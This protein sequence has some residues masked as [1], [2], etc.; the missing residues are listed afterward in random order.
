MIDL[1]QST[2]DLIRKE[3][4][5]IPEKYQK[6]FNSTHE[7]LGVLREEYLELE[8]EIFFGEKKALQDVKKRNEQNDYNQTPE[9]N[10]IDARIYHK[11]RIQKEAVQVA[12]MAIRI[13]QELTQENR[14]AAQIA[15]NHFEKLLASNQNNLEEQDNLVRMGYR[16]D[17]WK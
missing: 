9:F 4:N 5:S 14:T 10:Q 15:D 13:I 12:A 2:I 3:L 11:H 17:S 6:P 8:Q 7:G 1:N 16:P